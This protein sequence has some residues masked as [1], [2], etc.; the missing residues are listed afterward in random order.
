MRLEILERGHGRVNTFAL[1]AMRTL[2]RAEPDDVVKTSL[3]RPELFGRAWIALLRQTMRGRSRWTPGERELLGAFVSR[4]NQCPYC[5]RVH[6]G[7]ATLALRTPVDGARLERWRDGGF[8][9]RVTAAFTMLETLSLRPDEF[10]PP[11]VDAA[12]R[13]GLSTAEIDD[14]LHV[15]FLFNVINRVANAL[16]YE[17]STEADELASIRVLHRLGYRLPRLLLR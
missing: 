13:A 9:A 14:A 15:Q 4:L 5:T 17:W 3:Y 7:T 6:S 16:G 1:K 8:G 12:R 2:G 11:D 10:G